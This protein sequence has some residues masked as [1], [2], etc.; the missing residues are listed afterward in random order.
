MRYLNMRCVEGSTVPF[1][2]L[3]YGFQKL[4]QEMKCTNNVQ[5]A[6]STVEHSVISFLNLLKGGLRHS[7]A[8]LKTFLQNLLIF[9][10]RNNNLN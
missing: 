10:L 3:Y 7:V 8:T 2:K 5:N 4:K 1:C 6:S 9:R